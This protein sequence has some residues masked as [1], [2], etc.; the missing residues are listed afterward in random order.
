MNDTKMKYP[1]KLR[2]IRKMKGLKQIEVSQALGF[3]S[4]D[5]IC[6]WEKGI[7]V[8]HISNLAKLCKLFEVTFEALYP[9]LFESQTLTRNPNKRCKKTS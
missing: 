1:N 3:L 9:N 7:A 4:E 2:V 6:R 5:R 8:P